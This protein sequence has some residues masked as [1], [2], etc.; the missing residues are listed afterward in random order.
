[1]QQKLLKKTILNSLIIIFFI[2]LVS[3]R[4][5]NPKI[6]IVGNGKSDTLIFNS[7]DTLITHGVLDTIRLSSYSNHEVTINGSKPLKFR[8]SDKD[9]ILNTSKNEFILFNVEFQ[10]DGTE[11]NPMEALEIHADSYV[12]IDSFLICKKIF[13]K[14]LQDTNKLNLVLDS[15]AVSKNGNYKTSYHDRDY[16]S[17]YDED[18]TA[19]FYGFKKIG[20]SN[21]FIE[22]TW[23]Y[24]LNEEI[25]EEISVQTSNNN[26][27]PKNYI[28]KTDK[29]AIVMAKSFLR[30]ATINI[31]E[32]VVININEQLKKR[33]KKSPPLAKQ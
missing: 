29:T 19:S 14:E 23:D 33:A 26:Y 24:D 3:C 1:M 18:L 22:K 16:S 2:S 15:I 9:G 31:S 7:E 8:V 28:Q 20:A 13:E 6:T 10:S 21:I 5:D 17:Y 25:P 11:A 27:N 30:Y 12:K 4:R 32:Y